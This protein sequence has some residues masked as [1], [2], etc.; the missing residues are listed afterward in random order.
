MRRAMR[1]TAQSVVK[2]PAGGER[3]A[4]EEEAEY[5]RGEEE[6]E[7]DEFDDLFERGEEGYR[8]TGWRSID[9]GREGLV[10]P[11]G[12]ARGKLGC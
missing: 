3:A 6:S 9:G 8:A 7:G 2:Q 1:A 10:G 5:E 11:R 12:S 4:T